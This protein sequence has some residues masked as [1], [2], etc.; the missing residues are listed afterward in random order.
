M[1]GSS[2]GYLLKEGARNISMNAMMSL[3]SIGVLVSCLLLIGSSVMFSLNVKSIVGY[4]ES[5]NEV[6][7]FVLEGL[8]EEAMARLDDEIRGIGNISQIEYIDKDRALADWMSSM[9][10]DGQLL[11][12]FRYDNPLPNSYKMVVADLSLL[13]ETT[14]EIKTIIG[15]DHV[16]A[17]YEVAENVTGIKSAVDLISLVIV[18]ILGA[19]SFVV[20]T[21]TIKITVFNRRKE[22]SIMKYVGATDAFIR[23]PFLVEGILLGII[24]ATIA[25]GMLWG[26]YE[27][28]INYISTSSIQW[29]YIL[30]DNLV[31]FSIYAFPLYL[32]FLG[33][34]VLIGTAGS[35]SFIGKYI[36]V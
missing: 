30:G 34:G 20:V 6:V 2:F 22:I 12:M 13:R 31:E 28:L 16:N 8:D 5:Q 26:G 36:K 29:K 33:A 21:N 14:E 25:F 23:L 19:V 7:A 15:I 11:E 10:D 18:G 24:S 32:G 4:V 35:M 1:R 9:G 17:P 27:L 3:A